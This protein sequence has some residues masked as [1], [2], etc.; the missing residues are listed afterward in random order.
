MSSAVGVIAARKPSRSTDR[1][2]TSSDGSDSGTARIVLCNPYGLELF[3]AF[4]PVLSANAHIVLVGKAK[5]SLFGK[6]SD[7][8]PLVPVSRLTGLSEP[9]NGYQG[10][11][12]RERAA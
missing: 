7:S 11:V 10:P 2:L 5:D 8:R 9:G 1:M 4:H 3:N 12:D 6:C